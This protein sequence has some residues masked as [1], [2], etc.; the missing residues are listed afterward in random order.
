[1]TTPI[2]YLRDKKAKGCTR[3][4]LHKNRTRIVFGYGPET[5]DFMVVDAAPGHQ[6][7]VDGLPLVG[8]SG[9]IL[10]NLLKR[11]GVDFEETYRACLV[12][13]RP[14]GDRPPSLAEV[15]RCSLYLHLQ[16]RLVRPKV[17]LALGELA[18]RVL[19]GEENTPMSVLQ[20]RVWEYENKVTGY[21][22]PVV[23]THHPSWLLERAK[24]PRAKLHAQRLLGDVERAVALCQR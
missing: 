18:G 14:P 23:V 1:M 5:A 10:D 21:K 3:C 19:T 11:A 8:R 2:E 7:D 16:I 22:C 17:I 4:G 15:E 13:C 24:D 9:T 6:E 12:M 20:P